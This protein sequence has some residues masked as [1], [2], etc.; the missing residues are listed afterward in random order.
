M[1]RSTDNTLTKRRR[2]VLLL[3]LWAA[4]PPAC[5]PSTET[6]TVPD[7]ASTAVISLQGIDCEDCGTNVIEA[8][9]KQGIYATSF[10]RVK[11]ELTV[12][13]DATQI[14]VADMLAVVTKLGYT[15]IEGAG[16]GAYIP[17]VEFDP[18]SDVVEIAKAGEV[19]ELEPHLAPGKV[20]VFDFYAIWCEPCREVDEHMKTVL[21]EHDDVALRKLDIVDWDSEAAKHHMKTATSL[22]Y[23]I[24]YGPDGKKVAEISGL[25]L[26]ELDAAIAKGRNR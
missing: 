17:K 9:G 14:S 3:A 22:P 25:A 6:T 7:S 5:K 2:A 4:V 16:H 12:Q 26:D 13:Y 15:G 20:T 19:V 21:A 8:L 10:D 24:V 18:G 23:V 11:A 1:F